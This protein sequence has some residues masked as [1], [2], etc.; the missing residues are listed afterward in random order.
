M[1]Q[2]DGSNGNLKVQIWK[3][4]ITNKRNEREREKKKFETFL[5]FIIEGYFI[6]LRIIIRDTIKKNLVLKKIRW[7]SVQSRETNT[8]ETSPFYK[9]IIKVHANLTVKLFY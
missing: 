1:K 5:L 4:S 2:L 9:K 7:K 8:C 3:K 6:S